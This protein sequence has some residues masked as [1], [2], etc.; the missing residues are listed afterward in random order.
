MA[1]DAVP[2]SG[3]VVDLDPQLKSWA[4]KPGPELRVIDH[5]FVHARQFVTDAELA[6]SGGT[7]LRPSGIGLGRGA[8]AAVEKVASSLMVVDPMTWVVATQDN[9][10]AGFVNSAPHGRRGQL[11]LCESPFVLLQGDD[12]RVIREKGGLLLAARAS[13]ARV[14]V[15]TSQ[16]SFF[17][18]ASRIH[19][20]AGSAEVVL[21]GNPTIQS[22]HQHIKGMKPDAL[23]KLN[24][25]T[26]TVTVSGAVSE[27]RY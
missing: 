16:G 1:N 9:G 23:M 2:R 17:A 13:R 12:I 6:A 10:G 8:S 24:F 27:T 14:T 5:G 18:L 11:T 25:H 20:R 4:A 3:E 19:F 15:I 21:E 22:G 7:G 26:A